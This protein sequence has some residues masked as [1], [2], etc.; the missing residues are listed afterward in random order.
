M[1]YFTHYDPRDRLDP[2]SAQLSIIHTFDF[3]PSSDEL[4]DQLFLFLDGKRDIW[5][6]KGIT[7]TDHMGTTPTPQG[8]LPFYQIKTARNDLAMLFKLTFGGSL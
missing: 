8:Q 6:V 2:G 3:A 5:L 7:G 1:A 4:R